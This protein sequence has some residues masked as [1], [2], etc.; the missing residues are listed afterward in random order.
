MPGRYIKAVLD[1][2]LTS[3]DLKNVTT[4]DQDRRDELIA[5]FNFSAEALRK[6][7]G[8]NGPLDYINGLGIRNTDQLTAKLNEKVP[9]P[10]LPLPD[11]APKDMCKGPSLLMHLIDY[12][13]LLWIE[14]VQAHLIKSYKVMEDPDV[15]GGPKGQMLSSRKHGFKKLG[16]AFRGDTRS[17]TMNSTNTGSRLVTAS[18]RATATTSPRPT[19]PSP[20]APWPSIASDAI[21]S[22]KPACASPATCSAP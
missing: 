4:I 19:A 8:M 3:D 2:G 13:W 16:I 20:P 9:L 7:A 6:K 15:D 10:K 12:M 11:K 5:K 18:P 1:N 17:Y 21:S 22:T 14:P